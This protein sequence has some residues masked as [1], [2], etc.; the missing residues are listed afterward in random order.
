MASAATTT[1]PT[2]SL[3]D[4]PSAAPHDDYDIVT[5]VVRDH[6]AFRDAMLSI[7]SAR[8]LS[9]RERLAAVHDLIRLVA[10][11]SQA[12]EEILYP[13]CRTSMVEGAHATDDDLEFHSRLRRELSAMSWSSPG[14]PALD[15]KL[16]R[17]WSTLQEH[18]AE[19]ETTLL[20]A[21]A[22]CVPRE[23]RVAAGRLFAA[24]RLASC[25]RPHVSAPMHPPLNVIANALTAPLDWALD[26][27]RFGGAPPR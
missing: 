18:M 8:A 5:R 24:A 1:T 27:W 7:E 14:D 19:E 12:E 10:V 17:A 20:P 4:L 21:L 23:R 11:H 3:R 16:A 15:A 9:P 2:I 25:T 6:E 26:M 13:L 22:R